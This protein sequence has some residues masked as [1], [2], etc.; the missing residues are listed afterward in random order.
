MEGPI[1]KDK[2]GLP[3]PKDLLHMDTLQFEDLLND[4]GPSVKIMTISPSGDAPNFSRIR[5][6]L[7]R[8]IVPSL[9]HDKDCTENEILQCLAQPNPHGIRFHLTHAFNVS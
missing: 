9:G 2:G 1:I 3:D 5:S 8:G 7:A 6:L 4:L